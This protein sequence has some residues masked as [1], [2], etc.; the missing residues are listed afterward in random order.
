MCRWPSAE[1]GTIENVSS[2]GRRSRRGR[3]SSAP[4]ASVPRWAASTIAY[5][6]PRTISGTSWR[7]GNCINRATEVISAGAV[8]V[9]SRHACMTS[10]ARSKAKK[11]APA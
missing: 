3:S 8:A 4:S 7:S 10:D 6:R 9:H 1:G 5:E 2:S 11:S